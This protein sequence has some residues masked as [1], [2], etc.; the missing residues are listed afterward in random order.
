MGQVMF[1][2]HDL[3]RDRTRR[4]CTGFADLLV[5][6]ALTDPGRDAAAHVVNSDIL[7]LEL[8][9]EPTHSAAHTL[10]VQV[11]HTRRFAAVSVIPLR[12]KY[13]VADITEG[14]SFTEQRR[15]LCA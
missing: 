8:H 14:D 5:D 3:G 1:D 6:V 4:L 7:D 12:W 11:R 13:A 9:P 10:W 2:V 15:S